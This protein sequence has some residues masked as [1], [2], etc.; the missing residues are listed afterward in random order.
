MSH[1]SDKDNPKTF[2]SRFKVTPRVDIESQMSFDQ[3]QTNDNSNNS[4]PSSPTITMNGNTFQSTHSP[5][6]GPYTSLADYFQQME[7]DQCSEEK[8]QNVHLNTATTT[9]T[10][11]SSSFYNTIY[12]YNKLKQ[13]DHHGSLDAVYFPVGQY[14]RRSSKSPHS[15]IGI[16]FYNERV[17]VYN[18]LQRPTG[19]FAITYHISISIAV[20]YCLV[21]TILSTSSRRLIIIYEI[22]GIWITTLSPFSGFLSRFNRFYQFNQQVV[23]YDRL[24]YHNI[25]HCRIFSKTLGIR[26]CLLLPWLEGK[27]ALLQESNSNHR[28]IR[29]YH[30]T[31]RSHL[32]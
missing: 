18:F 9:S 11:S 23:E 27:G 22:I 31:S 30:L 8:N 13:S 20:I 32:K 5:L 7:Y 29:Y 14:N 15:S 28:L 25:L 6:Y 26:V 19:L 2:H 16:S 21:L 10:S 3:N 1:Q 24:H 12:K 17:H 4:L